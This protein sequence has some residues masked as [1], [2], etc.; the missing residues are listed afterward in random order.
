MKNKDL[1]Q[2]LEQFSPEDEVCVEIYDTDTSK[3]IDVSYDIG[4]SESEFKTLV[5]QVALNEK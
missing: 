2:L 5:L 1:I 3:I 4:F